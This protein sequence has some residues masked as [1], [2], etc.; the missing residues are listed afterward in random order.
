MGVRVGVAMLVAVAV[1]VGTRVPVAVGV[2][3]GVA[4]RVGVAVAPPFCTVTMIEVVPRVVPPPL[5]PFAK[6]V[7]LPL[8]T[9]VLSQ[10]KVVGGVNAK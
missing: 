5:N 2:V 1:A 9:V 7:W 4:V 3:T 10:L 8:M 6:I